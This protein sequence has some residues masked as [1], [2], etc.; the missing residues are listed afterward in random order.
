MKLRAKIKTY[1]DGYKDSKFN[2]NTAPKLLSLLFAIM[3][4]L[5]VIDLENPAIE[6]NIENVSVILLNEAEVSQNGLIILDREEYYIDVKVKGRRNEVAD[7]KSSDIRVTADLRGF[8]KGVNSIPLNKRIYS[9][10]VVISDLSQSEIKVVLDQMVEIAK[11]VSIKIEGKIPV[12]YTQDNILISPQEVLVR[13]PESIVNRVAQVSGTLSITG[14]DTS[15]IKEIPIKAIGNDLEDISGVTLGREYISAE[16]S[17][18]KTKKVPV[19]YK[20]EGELKKN[21]RLVN[22][23]LLTQFVTIKGEKDIIEKI[24]SIN[25]TPIDIAGKSEPF[26]EKIGIVLPENV[27]VLLDEKTITTNVMIEKMSSK[28]FKYIVREIP[29]FNLDPDYEA[30]INNLDEVVKIT[31]YDVESKLLKINSEILNPILDGSKFKEG[32]NSGKIEIDSAINVERYEINPGVINLE[33]KAKKV[34]QNNKTNTSAAI[35]EKVEPI[36]SNISSGKSSEMATENII[37]N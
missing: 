16:L 26:T 14:A 1:R 29:I 10:N 28:E 11:P 2:R 31:I 22:V 6:K 33:V 23:E 30:N 15:I 17:I 24:E 25:T 32:L 9:E 20:T 7:I 34:S 35:V 19:V 3:L 5:V 21:Y 13:G 27:E 18:Y 8:K 4:W 12:G 37:N 36:K